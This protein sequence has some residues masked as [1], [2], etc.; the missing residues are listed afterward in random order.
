MRTS[1]LTEPWGPKGP[2]PQDGPLERAVWRLRSRACWE[3]AAALIA[4]RAADDPGAARWRTAVL[5]E[6]CVFTGEGWGAAEDALRTAEALATDDEERGAAACERGH[7]AYAA[8]LL[9]VR[10]RADEARSALGRAAALL[11]PRSPGRP[12]LDFRRGLIAQHLSDNPSDATAAFQRAH[13]GAAAHGHG[14]LLSFTWRHMAAMA[15]HQ[16]RLADARHG[17]AESLRIREELGYLVGIAPA[18][19]SLAAVLPD[20]DEATRLRAEAARLVRLL[21]GVPAWLA[22]RLT[23]AR[24]SSSPAAASP[25]DTS[26]A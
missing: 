24:T 12:L 2:G 4:P 23:P 11:A 19:A 17:Y 25:P 13:A 5:V 18:L 21:G 22:D 1:G 6:R 14:L 15:E 8:T 9:G 16:G 10:D 3:D 20:P 7:L 26:G